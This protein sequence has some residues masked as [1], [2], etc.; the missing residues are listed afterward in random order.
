MKNV[1]AAN[2]V[3]T[4]TDLIKNKKTETEKASVL[5]N[6]IAYDKINSNEFEKSRSD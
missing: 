6:V 3:V 1:V 2:D 4:R 5:M